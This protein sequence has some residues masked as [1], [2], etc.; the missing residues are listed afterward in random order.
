MLPRGNILPKEFMRINLEVTLFFCGDHQHGTIE[1][2]FLL[3]EDVVEE[4]VIL[5]FLGKV[6]LYPG[7]FVFL[8]HIFFAL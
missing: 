1:T 4:N 2:G 3:E 8:C 5:Y 7:V 6:F